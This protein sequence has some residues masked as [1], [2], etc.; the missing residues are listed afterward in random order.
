M[1]STHLRF[2]KA[3]TFKRGVIAVGVLVAGLV[4]CNQDRLV[5]TGARRLSTAVRSQSLSRQIVASDP[6]RPGEDQFVRLANEIPGFA[7]FVLSANQQLVAFVKDTTVAR[8]SSAFA[9]S[10]LNAHLA[11]DGFGIARSA[12]PTSIAIQQ[13]DY[14]FQT[15]AGYRNFATDSLLGAV[16]GVVMVDLD[17]AINRVTIG[18]LVSRPNAQLQ[19]SKMLASHG[20]PLNAIHFIA[21]HGMRPTAGHRVNNM[22]HRGSTNLFDTSPNNLSAGF[23]FVDYASALECS[24]GAVVSA[25]GVSRFVSASHCTDSTFELY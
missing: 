18:T 16:S 13:A 23:V 10:A 1:V 17:E 15:L 25:S 9:A 19:A 3:R 21:G 20:I 12:R 5:P 6:R 2:M 4:A 14:D 24:V 8:T 11:N 22:R 7:G